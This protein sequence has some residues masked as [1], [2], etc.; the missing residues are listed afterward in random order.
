MAKI[1]RKEGRLERSPWERLRKAS[2][3]LREYHKV[4]DSTGDGTLQNIDSMYKIKR[5]RKK[6]KDSFMLYRGFTVDGRRL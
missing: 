1:P 5:I 6:H 4:I 3:E 2:A